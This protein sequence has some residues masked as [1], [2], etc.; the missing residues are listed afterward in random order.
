[1]QHH[2]RRLLGI[3]LIASLGFFSTASG[4]G[5]FTL[6]RGIIAGGGGTLSSGGFTLTGTIG[7][8]EA[9]VPLQ[10]GGFSLTGGGLAGPSMFTR[11]LPLILGG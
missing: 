4:Q 1:M 7:Q 6:S 2:K 5:G 9:G 11:Y 3:I 10:N 8:A